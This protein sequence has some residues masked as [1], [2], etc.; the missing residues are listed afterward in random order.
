METSKPVTS[1]PVQPVPPVV[2]SASV[3]TARSDAAKVAARTT[4]R[5]RLKAD[6]NG[7][8]IASGVMAGTGWVLLYRLIVGSPPLAFPRWL[9]FILLYIATTG[10]VL[11]F[12]WYLNR[13]FSRRHPASGGTILRE[14]TWIGLFVVTASWLQ[15]TRALTGIKA[16]F[17]ALS[18]VIIETF[19]RLR[20]RP[21]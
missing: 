13:L 10:T 18:I 20:E 15:M 7:V 9:F 6:Q 5:N 19:L 16:F 14:G 4:I 12:V 3:P 1:Q 2:Q 11:P 17:L 8:L 21:N